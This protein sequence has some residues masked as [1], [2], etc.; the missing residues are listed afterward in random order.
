MT[1]PSVHVTVP[2]FGLDTYLPIIKKERL[3]LE[4]YFSSGRFDEIRKSDIVALRDML[5]YNPKLTFHAPFMD[6][7]PAAVDPKIREVTLQRYD[8]VLDFAEILKPKAVVFHSGYYRWKYENKIDKWLKGSIKTWRLLN[9]RAEEMGVNIAIEN[10]FEDEPSNLRILAEEMDSENF[11]LCID[12]GHINLFSR[13]PSAR[14]KPPCAARWSAFWATWTLSSA[15]NS[16]Q[17]AKW[18]PR[19]ARKTT[20][21]A[22]RSRRSRRNWPAPGRKPGNRRRASRLLQR[23][24]PRPG[25]NPARPKPPARPEPVERSDLDCRLSA[26]NP[27]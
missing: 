15:R 1:Y 21:L 19:R 9:K 17:F 10:I 6:L 22:K 11:G 4:I 18:L 16:R 8:S 23:P 3:N 25:Q 12:V 26:T 13:I 2:Y 7:S 14:W 24:R 27:F 5:D 20:S